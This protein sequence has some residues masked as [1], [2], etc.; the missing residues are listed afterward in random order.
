[1]G[2]HS[3][4]KSIRNNLLRM[5]QFQHLK[6]LVE[7]REA[8][9]ATPVD[10]GTTTAPPKR[11]L[12]SR[13]GARVTQTA[14]QPEPNAPKPASSIS[15]LQRKVALNPT[16]LAPKIPAAAAKV[17]VPAGVK[18]RPAQSLGVWEVL[19]CLHP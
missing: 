16:A 8:S 19:G 13:L 18:V 11:K 6:P 17:G 12:L 1:M 9:E 3:D 10:A 2:G 7:A 14:G 5:K 15:T 4:I